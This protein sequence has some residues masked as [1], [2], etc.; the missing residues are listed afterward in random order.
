MQLRQL[1]EL[2]ELFKKYV[3]SFYPFWGIND[4]FMKR[5]AHFC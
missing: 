5:F 2:N 3:F 4:I 1:V